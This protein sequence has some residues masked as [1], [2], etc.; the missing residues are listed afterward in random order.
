[1]P[2]KNSGGG[3]IRLKS[4]NSRKVVGSLPIPTFIPTS[5]QEFQDVAR[6]SRTVDLPPPPQDTVDLMKEASA[7]F[8]KVQKA[9]NK[10]G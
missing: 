9:R 3:I 2:F 6:S 8:P 5:A 1:M 4:M 10:K 7:S